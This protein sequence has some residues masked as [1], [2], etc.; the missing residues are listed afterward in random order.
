[1]SI[2]LTGVPGD[3][4][5]CRNGFRQG[6]P[7]SPYLI[8]IVV[9]VLQ[10]LIHQAWANG[11]LL[12]PVSSEVPCPVLQYADDT[13]ILCNASPEAAACLKQIL[14]DFASA[15]GRAITFHKSCFIPMH[16]STLDDVVMAASLGC[17]ISSFPQPYLGN[18]A[19]D[20]GA[21]SSS[22]SFLKRIVEECLPLYRSI[23]LVEVAGGISTSFWFDKWLPANGRYQSA[24]PRCSLTAPGFMRPSRWCRRMAWSSSLVCPQSPS[25]SSPWF[26]KSSTAPCWPWVRTTATSA[27]P[28]RP[29]HLAAG[30]PHGVADSTAD[31]AARAAWALCLPTKLKIFSYLACIDSS[32]ANLFFKGCTP[33]DIC[34]ACAAFETCRHILFDYTLVASV[35]V[36]LGVAVPAGPFSFWELQRPAAIGDQVWRTGVVVVLWC[37]WKARNAVVFNNGSP[38]TGSI[39]R[40]VGEELTVWR[41]RFKPADRPALDSLCSFFLSRVPYSTGA[42]TMY[43]KSPA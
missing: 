36:R 35:W 37:I 30:L 12:H 32:R 39:L 29:L 14:N 11:F 2:L 41:W 3:W 31:Y 21:T 27:L 28:Q 15:T 34:A 5:L 7:L 9:D 23:T 17:P 18:S 22:P 20:L 6:D 25:T 10:R 1:M 19:C 33:S 4:I 43:P 26:A 8:I 42:P 16:V 13:L 24:S 38:S 40:T